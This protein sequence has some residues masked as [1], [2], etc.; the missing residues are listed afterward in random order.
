MGLFG[1]GKK[2]NSQDPASEAQ[3][4]RIAEPETTAS[5][6]A[7]L[8]GAVVPD[9]EELEQ[10][11]RMGLEC[12]DD[13]NDAAALQYFKKAAENGH[14]MAQFSLG[15]IFERGSLAAEQDL[16]QAMYWYKSAAQAGDPGAQFNLGYL[17]LQ[18]PDQQ[19]EGLKWMRSAAEQGDEAAREYIASLASETERKQRLKEEREQNVS[20]VRKFLSGKEVYILFSVPTGTPYLKEEGDHYILAFDTEQRAHA[21][22]EALREQGYNCR[23]I[24]VLKKDYPGVFGSFYAFGCNAARFEIDGQISDIYLYDIVKLAKK[25]NA[26]AGRAPVE[27]PRLIRAMLLFQQ[28]AGRR[29]LGKEPDETLIKSC[30]AEISNQLYQEKVDLIFP[31]VLQET[32][33]EKRKS[34]IIFRGN[35]ENAPARSVLLSNEAAFEAVKRANPQIRRR[36]MKMEEVLK[37]PPAGG[38]E[39]FIIDPNGGKIVVRL[40][41]K[42]A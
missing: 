4:E 18:D 39:G 27:N 23:V 42:E 12:Q 30:Q 1:F 9:E 28:E 5:D 41:K 40:T 33:G 26:P 2:K 19:E 36:V 15:M 21:G 3:N 6:D 7:A 29:A 38:T 31:Y 14:V 20:R 17:Y 16:G 25:K 37:L 13:G 8:S 10:L 24:R 34:P 22:R 32:D 11:Y 35:G